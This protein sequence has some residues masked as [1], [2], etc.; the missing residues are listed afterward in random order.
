[1]SEIDFT[2]FTMPIVLISSLVL[3]GI[4]WTAW[5]VTRENTSPVSTMESAGIW[6][7]EKMNNSRLLIGAIATAVLMA[8]SMRMN[9]IQ[10]Q[11]TAS[12]PES[13]ML[14]PFGYASLDAALIF[15]IAMLTL[16]IDSKWI[17]WPTMAWSAFLLCLSLWAAFSFTMAV[18]E[19][20]TEEASDKRMSG[21]EENLVIAKEKVSTWNDKLKKTTWL[22]S[23]HG[24][25]VDKA[26]EKRDEIQDEINALNVSSTPAV[27]AVFDVAKKFTGIAADK[28]RAIVRFLWSNALVITPLLMVAVFT[29]EMKKLLKKK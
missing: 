10:G 19:R 18:D 28:I 4:V 2:P 26:E 11:W 20:G 14:L 8:V 12:D 25:K 7:Y 5:K 9:Y 29:S 24:A 3:A 1:M 6:I 22:S 23:S 27:L 17:R 16:G 21:L 15:F 13:M